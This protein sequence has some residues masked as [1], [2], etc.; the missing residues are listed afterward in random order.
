MIH[1]YHFSTTRAASFRAAFISSVVDTALRGDFK[2]LLLFKNIL[3]LFL[4]YIYILFLTL[5]HQKYKKNIKKTSTQYI[6]SEI[7]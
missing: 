7:H 5:T 6:L 4:L 2:K 3:K 1:L